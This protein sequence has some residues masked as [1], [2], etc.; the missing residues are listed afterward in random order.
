MGFSSY[1]CVGCDAPLVSHWGFEDD[2]LPDKVKFL[3]R[4]VRVF[5]DGATVRGEWTGYSSLKVV[6][7]YDGEFKGVEI[8]DDVCH[9][10]GKR[11][12]IKVHLVEFTEK[13]CMYHEECWENLG[14]PK[15]YIASAS[16]ECQG[17]FFDSR[18]LRK[19]KPAKG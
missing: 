10:G 16:A 1:K 18:K 9:I 5:E 4:G 7:L 13:P 17:Y 3:Q 6:E 14:R 11:K 8:E 19:S 15:K 2:R 12:P